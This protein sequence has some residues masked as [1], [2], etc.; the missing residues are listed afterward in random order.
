LERAEERAARR[1][2]LTWSPDGAGG[3]WLRGRLDAEGTAV[4][5]AALD[6]LAAP[7]PSTADGPDPRSAGRRR[8][9]ALVEVCRRVLAGGELPAAGGSRPLVVVTVPLTTLTDRVGAGVLDDGTPISPAAARRL[10]CDAAVLPAVLGGAS[11]PLEL[12]RTRRLF[13]GPIRRA[14]VL[15]DRGCAFPGCDRP[16][17]WCEA[18]HIHHWADG[19]PT[20]LANGVLLCGTHHRLVEQGDWTVRLAADGHPDFHPPPWIDPT[21]HPRRNHLHHHPT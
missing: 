5:R 7:Q 19:G 11:Q 10:A 18:H 9:E 15:R 2:E 1:V 4:V 3:S 16:P 20:T 13:T 12:G 14:L 21:R 8:G 6:P 17:G